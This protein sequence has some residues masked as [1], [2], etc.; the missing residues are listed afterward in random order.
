MKLLPILASLLLTGSTPVTA[1]TMP[2]TPSKAETRAIMLIDCEEGFG[3]GFVVADRV[4]ATA[5]H[6]ASMHDCRIGPGGRLLRTYVTDPDHDFALMTADTTGMAHMRYSC[7][8][9]RNKE[10]YYSFGFGDGKPMLQ[11]MIASNGHVDGMRELLGTIISGQSGGPIVDIEGKAHGINNASNYGW[12]FS[13]STEL[14][15]TPLCR[16]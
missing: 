14:A 16:R 3:T 4:I 5:L 2:D 13:L 9:Y 15:D 7:I 11:R 12:G 1:D 8:R 6:V 10:H